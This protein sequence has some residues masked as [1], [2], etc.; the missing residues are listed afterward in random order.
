[1]RWVASLYSSGRDIALKFLIEVCYVFIFYAKLRLE[2]AAEERR[3]RNHNS[4]GVS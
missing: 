4:S 1:M 2:D 3:L